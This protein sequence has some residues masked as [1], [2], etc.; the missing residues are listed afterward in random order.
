MK[1]VTW[2]VRDFPKE[3]RE[4]V[5]HLAKEEGKNVWRI[6]S[7]AILAR[8]NKHEPSNLSKDNQGG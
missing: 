5:N 1:K 8:L 4:K 6:V 3:L 2:Q 7:E